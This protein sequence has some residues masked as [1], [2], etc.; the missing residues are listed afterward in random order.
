MNNISNNDATE[1]CAGATC[2]LPPHTA[3]KGFLAAGSSKTWWTIRTKD[4]YRQLGI[5]GETLKE[6][7]EKARQAIRGANAEMRDRHLE[8]TP[9]EKGNIQN[10]N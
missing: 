6:A 5:G 8:Q 2:S 4:G 3:E 9:P 10:E 7:R 1:G